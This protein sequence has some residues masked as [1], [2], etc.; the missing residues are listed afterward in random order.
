MIIQSS[1]PGKIILFGEH[2]SSRG[3]PAIIFAI[4]RRLTATLESTET[5]HPEIYLTSEELGIHQKKHP[6][7][8]LELISRTIELFLEKTN[9]EKKSFNLTFTS[10]IPAGCGSSAAAIVA[11]LGALNSFYQTN[12][13]LENLFDIG[14]EANYSVKGYGSG[15]DIAASLHGG[16]IFFEQGA[17]VKKLPFKSLNFIIGNTRK[18]VKSGPIVQM[19]KELEKQKPEETSWIFTRM[20]QIVQVAASA[21]RLRKKRKI[22]SLMNE[23]QQLLKRLGVSSPILDTLI[24]AARNAGAYGAK[25]SG[26]GKGDNMIAIVDRKTISPVMQALDENGA[27]II[28]QAQ[29]TPIGL[30]VEIEKK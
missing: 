21:I 23:N 7:E 14:Y 3:N 12:L 30:K 27:L 24:E 16:I 15:L 10:K 5:K 11:T 8:E 2:G 13:S 6:C 18:K 26:A 19:V 1:A 17:K 4:N 9:K 20:K 25:L 22:G 29:I 28:P